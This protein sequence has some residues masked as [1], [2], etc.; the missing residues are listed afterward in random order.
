MTVRLKSPRFREII[1]AGC[2]IALAGATGLGLL[3][4][5]WRSGDLG[6]LLALAGQATAV[7]VFILL[8][9]RHVRVEEVRESLR[10]SELL[11]AALFETVQEGIFLTDAAFNVEFVNDR[12]L[13]MTGR[14]RD[15]VIGRSI[16]TFVDPEDRAFVAARLAARAQGKRENYELRVPKKDGGHFLANISASPRVA[17]DGTFRGTLVT[18]V[19]ATKQAIADERQSALRNGEQHA[20]A[21]VAQIALEDRSLDR[22]FP[23]AARATF[24]ALGLDLCNIYRMAA[25]Q[26]SLEI[27]A[28]V[29]WPD[30]VPARQSVSARG[31]S[32]SARALDQREPLIVDDLRRDDS[33]KSVDDLLER[34]I[35]SSLVAV[36]RLNEG[37]FGVIGCHSLRPSR[38]SKGDATFVQAMAYVLATAISRCRDA[39]ALK[40]ER[41]RLQGILD[42]TADAIVTLDG[43]GCI[44]QVNAAAET[45]FGH[46][47]GSLCGSRISRILP[48][49]DPDFVDGMDGRATGLNADTVGL[50]ADAIRFPVELSAGVVRLGGERRAILTIRD[51]SQ[52]H[53]AEDQ[54]R[55]A[56][57]MDAVGQLTGGI[58]HDFN[59]LLT[60]IV[61]NAEL[62][63]DALA[64]DR[65]LHDMADQ[66]LQAAER[67]A[68]LTRRL[69]AFS[70]R[71]T[72]QPARIDLRETMVAMTDML[73]RTLGGNI[74]IRFD[75]QPDLWST[76]VDRAQFET[77][78]LNL[79]L[80]A[81]DA[82]A[83]G[84]RLT[85][86]ARNA[87]IAEDPARPQDEIAPGDYVALA[88]SDT[89]TGMSRDVA[90][91]AFEPFFT[92]KDVGKGT[93]LGLSMVYGFVKQSGGHVTIDS[94]PQRGATVTIY[95]PRARSAEQPERERPGPSGDAAGSG[96]TVLVVEDDPGVRRQAVDKLVALGY[97]VIEASDGN[98]ALQRL[99]A[100]DPIDLLFT[101]LVMPG[102]VSGL[103]VARRARDLRPTLPVLFT[104]GYPTSTIADATG[105]EP[106]VAVLL[107]P[108]R[109]AE[110]ARLIRDALDGRL[111]Q[112]AHVDA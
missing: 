36:I 20:I 89:G 102:G 9:R 7:T 107:K 6:W 27:Q 18:V 108:Y 57:K 101:D 38:F 58:A 37:V 59:N 110:L 78:V 23:A 93:G 74:E 25:D 106:N 45:I 39:E 14:E 34:G 1:V 15:E 61:G 43:S 63:A 44:E 51:V 17:A 52:R 69:L 82:M 72:L 67:G 68:S 65:G 54:L 42:T 84:G 96:E 105:E 80:N 88:V 90:A 62:L 4:S 13:E 40:D 98:A 77:A 3:A 71:Q 35:R 46:T 70:R 28:R 109:K 56:Q 2:A 53:A 104:S 83:Q 92:T 112:T 91:R 22:L 16:A 79:A 75:A 76:S 103:A 99:A 32:L 41:V 97:R 48:E 81:R 95:M 86:T 30:G 21:T 5:W 8:W 24:D 94:A 11:Y 85:I 29:G 111:S 10:H 26:D 31:Y 73:R 66:V 47:G 64:H 100:D 50:R 49:C 33:L 19:D 12:L 60:V 87:T 55:Q